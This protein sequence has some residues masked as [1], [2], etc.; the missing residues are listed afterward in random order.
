MHPGESC[1]KIGE[2]AVKK[3]IN[4]QFIMISVAAIILTLIFVTIAYY[5]VL[6]KKK[7]KQVMADLKTFAELISLN[8]TESSENIEH[9]DYGADNIRGYANRRFRQ[10]TL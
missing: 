9:I 2:T 5:Q 8:G 6:K 3:R 1:I 7:K 4:L 10:S